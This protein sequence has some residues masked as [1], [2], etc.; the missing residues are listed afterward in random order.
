MTTALALPLHDDALAERLSGRVALVEELLRDAVTY[1]DPIAHDASRHLVDAGGKRLRPLLTLLTAELGDGNRREVIDAA[2]VVE[3]THLATL[4]HDDVMDSAPLRRGAPSAHEV[5]G[6]SVA[7]L[8]G[9]LLFARASSIVSGLGPEAVRIQAQTFERLCL[10]QLHETVGPRPDEDPVEHYL[11]VLADK[12]ASLIA[13]SARFGAMFAGCRPDVVRTVTQFGEIVGVAFQLAD[14]VIDL[15]SDGSVTGKT[16][17]T[18]L[19][20][21]VPTMPALLLRSRA[22]QTPAGSR[23]R[24]VVALLDSDLTAD[25]DLAVAV[26]AL[27]EHEVVTLTRRRAVELARQAVTELGPLP[28]GPVKDALVAFADALVDRAS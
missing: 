13:T 6:N 27:R 23:D 17:G 8:T 7:I 2:A 10:G 28:A 26:E 24:D 5:W 12:T 4:Y 14:D 18:D 22:A 3:L 15:T 16:P 11:Q 1:A 9:D 25:A 19:R 20:E 21:G